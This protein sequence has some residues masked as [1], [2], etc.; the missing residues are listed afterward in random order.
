MASLKGKSKYMDN[1]NIAEGNKFIH[2]SKKHYRPHHYKINKEMQKFDNDLMWVCYE[3][4]TH[5]IDVDFGI[6]QMTWKAH[7]GDGFDSCKDGN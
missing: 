1:V 6:N 5:T 4:K 3:T 2:P 7:D